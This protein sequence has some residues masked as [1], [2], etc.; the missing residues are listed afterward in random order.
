MASVELTKLRNYCIN[1]TSN[2]IAYCF[3]INVELNVSIL[4][5]VVK[6]LSTLITNRKNFDKTTNK[7]LI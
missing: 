3:E 1:V 2:E 7:N 4:V 6:F 5:T